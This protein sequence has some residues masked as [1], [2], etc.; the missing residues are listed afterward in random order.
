MK[1]NER[2]SEKT[3]I[4]SH[5]VENL[6]SRDRDLFDGIKPGCLSRADM[7]LLDLVLFMVPVVQHSSADYKE[8]LGALAPQPVQRYDLHGHDINERP[9]RPFS[10]LFSPVAGFVHAVA[11]FVA[12]LIAEPIPGSLELRSIDTSGQLWYKFQA[13]KQACISFRG[14]FETHH[15][16]SFADV[17]LG[18]RAVG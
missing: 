13:G 1:R 11:A 7:D 5:F 4:L 18:F 17:L 8:R 16:A 6:Q 10:R 15:A 3:E 14:S 2:E 9:P 12:A